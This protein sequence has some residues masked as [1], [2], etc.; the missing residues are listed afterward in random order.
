M[1]PRPALLIGYGNPGRGDDGLGPAFVQ[2]IAE[3]K[4]PGLSVKIDYQLMVD[5]AWMIS[6]YELVI[7]ADAVLK[8]D[9]PFAFNELTNCAPRNMGSHSVTPEAAVM[10]SQLLFHTA[11]RAFVLGISGDRFGAI[12]EGLSDPAFRNLD[13]A[14]EFFATWYAKDRSPDIKVAERQR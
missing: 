5:H 3:R 6:Q 2:R 13:L 10:L 7:F 4:L 1:S 11:P 8:G 9:A 12:E 14:E